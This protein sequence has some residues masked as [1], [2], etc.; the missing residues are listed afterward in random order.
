[1]AERGEINN[2]LRNLMTSRFNLAGHWPLQTLGRRVR[3]SALRSGRRP[4]RQGCL[5][6][7][8]CALSLS[9]GHP[10]VSSLDIRR[11]NC[12]AAKCEN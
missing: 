9:Y 3:L 5:D 11:L 12:T 1:M 6:N 2:A 7:N 10:P 8:I 4:A